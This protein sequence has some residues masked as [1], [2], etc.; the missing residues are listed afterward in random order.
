LAFAEAF[1]K[2][3]KEPIVEEKFAE[4]C[5]FRFLENNKKPLKGAD[6]HSTN[7]LFLRPYSTNSGKVIVFGF[8]AD[9]Q[10]RIQKI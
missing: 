4:S 8:M 10:G 5:R 9:L 3:L 2:A 1:L 6:M 7:V